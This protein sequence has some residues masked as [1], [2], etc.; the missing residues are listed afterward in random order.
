MIKVLVIDGH[1]RRSPTVVRSLGQ[2]NRYKVIVGSKR[3]INAAR[4]SRYCHEFIQYPDPEDQTQKFVDFLLDYLRNGKIDVLLPMDDTMAETI[5]MNKAAFEKETCLLIPDYDLFK[6]ARDKGLTIRYARENNIPHPEA[7][8]Y[9]RVREKEVRFPLI[10][11]PRISTA[12]MGIRIAHD[13]KEL[14]YY[15]GEVSKV[16]PDPIIQEVIP[17]SGGHLQANLLFDNESAVKACCVKRKI[18]QY[19]LTGGPSTFFRTEYNKEIESKAIEILSVLKWIGPAEVEFMIDP[20]DEQ[21]KI[22]EIN[23]RLSATLPL[24]YYAGVDFPD[25]MVRCALGEN[26]EIIFNKNYDY[27]CQWLIPGDLLNFLFNKDRFKQE[28][29][30]FFNKPEKLCHMIFSKE[31]VLP[32]IANLVAMGISFFSFKKLKRFIFR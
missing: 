29:G 21:P 8:D 3:K 1:D 12:G 24:S 13:M 19:P 16:Y 32:F 11:K 15:Y 25:L 9:S 26:T 31:D 10:I 6:V 2:K 4:F 14:D 18:R 27:Y 5:S 17:N 30:Y 7:Y 23:P 22:M 20:R 28:Y